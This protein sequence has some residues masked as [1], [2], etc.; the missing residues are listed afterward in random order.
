MKSPHGKNCTLRHLPSPANALLSQ[1]CG[2][3]PTGL[4]VIVTTSQ[5]LF[6]QPQSCSNLA[7]DPCFCNATGIPL[8]PASSKNRH[9]LVSTNRSS[10]ALWQ[11]TLS[12]FS[13]SIDFFNTDI[14]SASLIRLVSPTSRVS[15]WTLLN[16]ASSCC[17][18]SNCSWTPSRMNSFSLKLN[19]VKYFHQL[20]MANV[21]LQGVNFVAQLLLNFFFLLLLGKHAIFQQPLVPFQRV[22]E[23]LFCDFGCYQIFSVPQQKLLQFLQKIIH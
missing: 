9:E 11:L 20:K 3:S 14:N 13:S 8:L 6:A 18:F 16:A 4:V 23:S 22:L 12:E 2:F 5:N 10:K 19:N 15:S 17:S 7:S 21:S 1:N